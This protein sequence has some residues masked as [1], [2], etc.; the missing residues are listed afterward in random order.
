MYNKE[1][2]DKLKDIADELL[3]TLEKKHPELAEEFAAIRARVDAEVEEDKN[4]KIYCNCL[5]DINY[6]EALKHRFPFKPEHYSG[7]EQIE[8]ASE[9]DFKIDR[10]KGFCNTALYFLVWQTNGEPAIII[11]PLNIGPMAISEIH[12]A[13][14]PEWYST[15]PD[16][17][18]FTE[19]TLES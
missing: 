13:D 6:D 12:H 15:P 9:N 10:N 2:I 1:E 14:H 4:K 5:G 19:E 17:D 11:R 18:E 16:F 8:E 7:I 3:K